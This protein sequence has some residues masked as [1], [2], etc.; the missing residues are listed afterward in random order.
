MAKAMVSRMLATVVATV[1]VADMITALKSMMIVAWSVTTT[2]VVVAD[3]T[4]T[5]TKAVACRPSIAVS[6]MW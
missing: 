4:I 6:T 2:V 5:G 3:L 1:S